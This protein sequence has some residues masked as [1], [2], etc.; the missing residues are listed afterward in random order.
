MILSTANGD[1]VW[2]DLS[3]DRGAPS[4]FRLEFKA[5]WRQRQSAQSSQMKNTPTARADPAST[6]KLSIYI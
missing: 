6:G 5:Q 1:F 2:I 4:N 3:F